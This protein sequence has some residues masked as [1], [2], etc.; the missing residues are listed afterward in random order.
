MS[1]MQSEKK[2]NDWEETRNI[3]KQRKPSVASTHP[4]QMHTI[5]QTLMRRAGTVRR[6]GRCLQ[7]SLESAPECAQDPDHLRRC[8][9]LLTL[10]VTY[11]L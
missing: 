6:R 3:R 1:G 4:S 2:K 5:I 10:K 8:S 7:R 11:C 9:I